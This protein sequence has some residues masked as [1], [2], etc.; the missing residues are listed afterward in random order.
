MRDGVRIQRDPVAGAKANAAGSSIIVSVVHLVGRLCLS[1]LGSL[2]AI[3][4]RRRQL[5]DAAILALPPCI[6]PEQHMIPHPSIL[7]WAAGRLTA[8]FVGPAVVAPR[9]SSRVPRH[10]APTPMP[11]DAKVPL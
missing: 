11:S 5:R 6:G 10:A 3:A 2:P 8:A 4:P 7:A 9:G 1:T